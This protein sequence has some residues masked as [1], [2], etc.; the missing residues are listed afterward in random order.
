M[1]LDKLTAVAKEIDGLRVS[2]D[3]D[4]KRPKA[5]KRKLRETQPW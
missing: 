2:E 4:T 1:V 5:R 3:I